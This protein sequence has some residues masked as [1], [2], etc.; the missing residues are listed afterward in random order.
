[1]L[2]VPRS[3]PYA[4]QFMATAQTKLCEP[5]HDLRIVGS[6][7]PMPSYG[8]C[9]ELSESH[10]HFSGMAQALSEV[11]MRV[12]L[13]TALDSD[14]QDRT[15]KCAYLASTFRGKVLNWFSPA[16]WTSYWN[17]PRTNGFSITITIRFFND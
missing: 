14:L 11:L 2:R 7:A 16:Y 8:Y 1:M 12:R 3:R 9:Y 17:C 15:A 5:K 10:I 6:T 13:K 4:N